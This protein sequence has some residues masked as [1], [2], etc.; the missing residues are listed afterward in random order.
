MKK[1]VKMQL[2]RRI[3]LWKYL[4]LVRPEGIEPSAFGTGI[5]RSI[6]LNYGRRAEIAAKQQLYTVNIKQIC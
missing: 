2:S 5:Q 3:N 4:H 6:Q 1:M